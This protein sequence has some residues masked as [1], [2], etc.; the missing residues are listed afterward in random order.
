MKQVLKK[1]AKNA[2]KGGALREKARHR[3]VGKAHE[4]RLFL[5]SDKLT[6]MMPPENEGSK[7]QLL[8]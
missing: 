3:K 6:E 5:P 7:W 8:R 2:E 1:F 4:S